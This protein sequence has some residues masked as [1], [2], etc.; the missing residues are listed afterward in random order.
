MT[1]FLTLLLLGAAGSAS[2]LTQQ[3]TGEAVDDAGNWYCG[4]VSQILY[5]GFVTSGSYQQVTDMTDTG[6]CEMQAKSYSGALSPLNEDVRELA[7]MV[8]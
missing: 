6:D 2:A 7:P 5:E 1:K 4:A 3:C 8:S